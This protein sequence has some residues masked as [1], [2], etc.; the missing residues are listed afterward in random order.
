MGYEGKEKSG[1]KGG[2]REG[3]YVRTEITAV[4]FFE[5]RY[6]DGDMDKPKY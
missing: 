1:S 5:N 3:R 2:Q 6:D 4:G